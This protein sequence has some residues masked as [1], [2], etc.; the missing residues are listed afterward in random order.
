MGTHFDHLE[1]V[2][3]PFINQIDNYIYKNPTNSIDSASGLDIF[4][5]KQKDVVF[6]GGD[7]AVHYHPHVAHWLHLES[8][9]SLLYTNNELPFIPQNRLNNIAKIDFKNRKGINSLSA[10][11][12]HFFG[13]N[14]VA[15]YEEPS[16]PYQLINF[17]INGTI[18]GNNKI[19]YAVGVNLSL[20][21]I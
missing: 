4:N 1:I 8:N 11:Y 20:I 2:I 13:Q 19:D 3:N 6:S 15:T 9:F 16:D 14:S 10:Q 18:P 7:I 5:M 21:H 12:I 17:S